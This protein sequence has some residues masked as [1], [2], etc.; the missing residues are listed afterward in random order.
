MI[1]RN[2]YPA[3]KT[4]LILTSDWHMME[5]D[6]KPPCRIDNHFE[7]QL[8]KVYQIMQIQEFYDCDIFNA[9]DIFEHWKA[10]PELIN[11]CMEIFP[12]DMWAIAGQ[13]D[14][15]KHNLKLIYKS[16][17]YTLIKSGSIQFLSNQISWNKYNSKK[18]KYVSVNGKLVAMAHMLIYK[19][20]LPFPDCPAPEVNKVFKMFPLADLIVTGDNHQTF[21]ARK[22]KQLLINPGS[23]T[24]H[25]ADQIDH[26]PCVFLWNAKT[27]G[28]KKIY[29]KIK[30][31]VISRDHIDIIAAKKERR[32]AYVESL[33]NE[34]LKSLS[35]EGNM[36][37]A[38]AINKVKKNISKHIYN[39]MDKI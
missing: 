36:A 34:W 8:K 2:L 23:L 29:L 21:W 35:F 19:G 4:D 12:S 20:D 15:P 5:P 17:F 22:G 11:K 10:S 26:R 33:S 37:V 3:Y 6:R 31:D 39:W 9:G 32:E 38:I 18:Q 24:R 27:N 16:A 14:L 25:K 1:K 28:F 30:K 13:H 7:A